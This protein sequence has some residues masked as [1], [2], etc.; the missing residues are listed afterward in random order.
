M[1]A[2]GTRAGDHHEALMKAEGERFVL[3]WRYSDGAWCVLT[4]AEFA[5]ETV[6]AHIPMRARAYDAM[7]ALAC[8]RAAESG[9][10]AVEDT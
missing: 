2:K 5:P 3:R 4:E 7:R 10:L 8:S 6:R 9:T 1:A